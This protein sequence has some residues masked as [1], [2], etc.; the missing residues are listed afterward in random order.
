MS[1]SGDISPEDS[2]WLSI[3]KREDSLAEF[4]DDEARASLRRAMFPE[5]LI[6]RL[7]AA[8]SRPDDTFHTVEMHGTGNGII[9]ASIDGVQVDDILPKHGDIFIDS[10]MISKFEKAVA[11]AS[12]SDFLGVLRGWG[13]SVAI[14]NDYRFAG[15]RMTFWLF[16]HEKSKRYI[17]G[18]GETD[19]VALRACYAAAQETARETAP[20]PAPAPPHC[21]HGV[22]WG[23]YCSECKMTSSP[24]DDSMQKKIRDLEKNNA[25]LND[26][27]NSCRD[28]LE[29]VVKQRNEA[30]AT[31]S[32]EREARISTLD[33]LEV[34]IGKLRE[35][36]NKKCGL[37]VDHGA[38]QSSRPERVCRVCGTDRHCVECEIIP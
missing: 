10:D 29:V 36:I 21:N 11:N 14:H 2:L 5:H 9:H 15:K 16:T 13:W 22:H 19:L 18:E 33:A 28:T 31:L 38:P 37:P 1:H 23:Y 25:A 34:E 26:A 17:K 35:T 20:R 4:S 32:K 3:L 30:V 12:V 24:P 6:D 8:R 7:L 27:W